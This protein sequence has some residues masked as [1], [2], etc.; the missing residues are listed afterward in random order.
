LAPNYN[1]AIRD[2]GELAKFALTLEWSTDLACGIFA[3]IAISKEQIK[4]AHVILTLD[5]DLID[6][7]LSQ[8]V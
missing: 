2:V 7:F 8:Y 4:L 5:D 3:A 6:E 1:N